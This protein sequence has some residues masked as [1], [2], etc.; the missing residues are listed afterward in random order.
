MTTALSSTSMDCMPYCECSSGAPSC[1][2]SCLVAAL[3]VSSISCAAELDALP[4][5]KLFRLPERDAERLNSCQRIVLSH[6]YFFSSV[7]AQSSHTDLSLALRHLRTQT[8]T[9]THAVC[10]Y[11]YI[12]LFTPF[13]KHSV[14]H[15]TLCSRT[16]TSQLY[17]QRR[18]YTCTSPPPSPPLLLLSLSLSLSLSLLRRPSR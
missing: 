14:V 15:Y 11:I 17:S 16:H 9:H 18:M 2:V 13:P 3:D 1:A 7:S 4:E 12:P 5:W 6:F 10:M 8:H